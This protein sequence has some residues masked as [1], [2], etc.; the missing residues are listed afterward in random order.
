MPHGVGGGLGP[1]RGTG[2]PLQT[3]SHV[4]EDVQKVFRSPASTALWVGGLWG[5]S[6]S[7]P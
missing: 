2:T 7:M 4:T 5:L 1:A 3:H 6:L